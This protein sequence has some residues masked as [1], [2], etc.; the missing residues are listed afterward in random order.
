MRKT[1][2]NGKLIYLPQGE[3]DGVPPGCHDG[4]PTRGKGEGRPAGEVE[5]YS[6]ATRQ[7][8]N[9]KIVLLYK[10]EF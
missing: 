5:K 10:K 6:P 4:A 8:A 7:P 3:R 9:L 1:T 2:Y